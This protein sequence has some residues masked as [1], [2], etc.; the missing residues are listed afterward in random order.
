LLARYTSI[1]QSEW[2]NLV[3]AAADLLVFFRWGLNRPCRYSVGSL[4]DAGGANGRAKTRTKP[5]RPATGQTFNL[6]AKN[7]LTTLEHTHC[8]RRMLEK[9]RRL[10][11]ICRSPRRD[12]P[13]I[14]LLVYPPQAKLIKFQYN[15]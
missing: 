13:A 2:L 12:P 9:H 15:R 4:T 1:V 5:P 7:K 8:F 10:L 3:V 6:P 14:Q 11:A